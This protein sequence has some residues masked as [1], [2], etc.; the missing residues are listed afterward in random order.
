MSEKDWW[1]P[2]ERKKKFNSR[3][4]SPQFL[5]TIIHLFLLYIRISFYA[6]EIKVQS[7]WIRINLKTIFSLGFG[8]PSTLKQLKENSIKILRKLSIKSHLREQIFLDKFHRSRPG[9]NQTLASEIFVCRPDPNEQV[10]V[11]N[12]K[13]AKNVCYSQFFT[14]SMT[15]LKKILLL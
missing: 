4:Q 3:P 9:S 10:N 8:L 14:L 15:L 2:V 12:E 6:F 7:T 11:V 13:L 1:L 5:T